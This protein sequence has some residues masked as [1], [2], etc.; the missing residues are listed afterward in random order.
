MSTLEPLLPAA[1]V[2]DPSVTRILIRNA[3]SVRVSTLLQRATA[4]RPSTSVI[5]TGTGPINDSLLSDASAWQATGARLGFFAFDSHNASFATGSAGCLQRSD[6]AHQ[7]LP[8]AP[9]GQL[10]GIARAVESSEHEF[11]VL[12]S[13][14]SDSLGFLDQCLAQMWIDG[15][16]VAVL[17]LDSTGDSETTDSG[18]AGEGIDAGKQLARWIASSGTQLRNNTTGQ[19]CS[20]Q[21]VVVMRRWVARWLFNEI[22][23]AIDPV[24]EIA[25]R[26]RLLGVAIAVI[27]QPPQQAPPQHPV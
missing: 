23:R 8:A 11:V 7:I 26:A 14:H 9:G 4:V 25:D 5:L 1:E 10:L 6:V 24:E 3:Q 19:V 17:Q 13:A 18:L 20:T 12:L 2:S 15:A 22:G 21:R 16:D 27:G